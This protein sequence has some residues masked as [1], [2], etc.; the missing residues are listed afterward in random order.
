MNLETEFK[1]HSI[2]KIKEIPKNICESL[3]IDV[4]EYHNNQEYKNEIDD[5]L[6]KFKIS[7]DYLGFYKKDNFK[8]YLKSTWFSKKICERKISNYLKG[9]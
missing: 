1:K 4:E 8:I 6:I 3:I 5:Q 2:E 9:E 7:K